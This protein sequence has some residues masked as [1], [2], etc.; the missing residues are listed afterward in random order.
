M[1]VKFLGW[2]VIV[3]LGALLLCPAVA[4]FGLSPL[5][6]DFSLNYGDSRIFVP[7]GTAMI[8]SGALTL[9]FFILRR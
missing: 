9:L 8:A 4:L 2:I 6:G 5:P 1:G 3:I 7:L